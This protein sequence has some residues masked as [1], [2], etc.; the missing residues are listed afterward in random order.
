MNNQEYMNLMNGGYDQGAIHAAKKG[1]I[2]SNLK[3]F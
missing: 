3:A 1:G 2:L